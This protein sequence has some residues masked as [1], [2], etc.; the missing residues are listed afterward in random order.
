MEK[1]LSFINDKMLLYFCSNI[2]F[3][4]LTVDRPGLIKTP[5]VAVPDPETDKMGFD[6][7]SKIV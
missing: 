3:H 6:Q 5:Y 7:V 4:I 1:R 2:I